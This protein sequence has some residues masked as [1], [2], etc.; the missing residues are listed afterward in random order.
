MEFLTHCRA[1]HKI[2]DVMILCGTTGSGGSIRKESLLPSAMQQGRYDELPTADE[3]RRQGAYK[4]PPLTEQVRDLVVLHTCLS[5]NAAVILLKQNRDLAP[6][7]IA[8]PYLFLQVFILTVSQL[9]RTDAWSISRPPRYRSSDSVIWFYPDSTVTGHCSTS[10]F[11]YSADSSQVS[12]ASAFPNYQQRLSCG[13]TLLCGGRIGLM[14]VQ[15]WLGARSLSAPGIDDAVD[16]AHADISSGSCAQAGHMRNVVL[17]AVMMCILLL[18]H[19][20]ERGWGQQ[21]P[22]IHWHPCSPHAT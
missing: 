22:N 21:H 1:Q 14:R 4:D 20:D 6:D 15:M 3:L 2:S 17:R 11:W 16:I 19:G 9:S 18:V 7:M 13:K 8:K 5:A 10:A 12:R